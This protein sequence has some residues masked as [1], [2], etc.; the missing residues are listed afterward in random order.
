MCGY[1]LYRGKKRG[2]EKSK[3]RRG[4]GNDRARETGL[5]WWCDNVEGMRRAASNV[6][7]DIVIS[8]G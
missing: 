5:R 8:A 6:V 4:R 3:Q 1:E 2:D 7:H